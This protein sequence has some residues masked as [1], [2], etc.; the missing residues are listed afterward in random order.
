M[1]YKLSPGAILRFIDSWRPFSSEITLRVTNTNVILLWVKDCESCL[2]RR[3]SDNLFSFN[4]LLAENTTDNESSE[5]H[6]AIHQPVRVRFTMANLNIQPFPTV[7]NLNIW[8]TL[9]ETVGK[10]ETKS[11]IQT[12]IFNTHW[13]K[14]GKEK[15]TGCLHRAMLARKWLNAYV[16]WLLNIW[17]EV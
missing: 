6:R 2:K 15:H 16:G 1:I 5:G 14:P 11:N 4:H 9:Q 10:A 12:H 3:E 7:A 17:H 8:H 13:I